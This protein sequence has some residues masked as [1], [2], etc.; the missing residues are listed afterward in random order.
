MLVQIACELLF[1]GFSLVSHGS[2]QCSA[3]LPG[4]LWLI[5]SGSPWV[6]LALVGFYVFLVLGSPK[7]SLALPWFSFVV[8]GF[9]CVFWCSRVFGFLLKSV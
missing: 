3:V 4:S 1:L 5:L 2:P 6:S 8:I 7:F 9:P